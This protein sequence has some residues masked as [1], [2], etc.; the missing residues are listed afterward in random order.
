MKEHVRAQETH[1][2]Q[3]ARRLVRRRLARPRWRRRGWRDPSVVGNDLRG[4]EE[5]GPAGAL[6][7]E[8]GLWC[9]GWGWFVGSW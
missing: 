1:V 9:C 7:L 5:R 4:L 8:E 3:P 6:R 2:R